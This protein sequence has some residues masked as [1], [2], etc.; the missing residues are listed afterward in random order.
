MQ[1]QQDRSS[2]HDHL[3]ASHDRLD[4]VHGHPPLASFLESVLIVS[5]RVLERHQ[6]STTHNEVLQ[7]QSL[8]RIEM[9]TSPFL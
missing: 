3:S 8:T 7:R 2:E 6:T 9:H 5:G 4:A 1:G